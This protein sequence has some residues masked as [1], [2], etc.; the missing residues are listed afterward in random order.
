MYGSTTTALYNNYYINTAA[1]L[2]LLLILYLSVCLT[3][4][5]IPGRYRNPLAAMYLF[6][7]PLVPPV[8]RASLMPAQ[9]IMYPHSMQTDANASDIPY[10]TNNPTLSIHERNTVVYIPTPRAIG[11]TR[12]K[13]SK[14]VYLCDE[15]YD[16]NNN[17]DG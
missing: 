9:T 14:L 12:P 3:I 11:H 2:L 1:V 7:H 6:I 10:H 5:Y 15:L 16:D 17:A 4:I 8:C 13:D